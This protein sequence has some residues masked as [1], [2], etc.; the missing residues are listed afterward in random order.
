MFRHGRQVLVACVL[1][2]Y[3]LVSVCGVSLHSVLEK[4]LSHHDHGPARAAGATISGISHNC[5]IC[6]F[7][8][9]GQL[10]IALPL[11]VSRALGT[12]H[13]SLAP[14]FPETPARYPSCNPRAPPHSSRAEIV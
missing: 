4:T 12:F 11:Q 13:L 8:A 9:Q 5:L 6:E 2:L 1:T 10:P 3:G 14:A 7:A